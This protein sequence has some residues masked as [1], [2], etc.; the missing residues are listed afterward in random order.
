MI[1]PSGSHR[2]SAAAGAGEIQKAE[3]MRPI[4]DHLVRARSA[5]HSTLP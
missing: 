5:E 3:T 4:R 2:S 1:S